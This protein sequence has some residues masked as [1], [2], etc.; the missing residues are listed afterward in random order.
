MNEYRTHPIKR[1][2][3]KVRANRLADA[4]W[5]TVIFFVGFFLIGVGIVLL[6]LPGPGWLMIFLGFLT[7]AT[8]FA[9]ASRALAPLRSRLEKAKLT[10]KKPWWFYIL[11]I[12]FAI[13]SA[14]ASYWVWITFEG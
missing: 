1:I 9:W 6:V 13:A 14:L 4:A 12:V 11:V 7:L 5:R 8:E 3:A 10:G 2:R